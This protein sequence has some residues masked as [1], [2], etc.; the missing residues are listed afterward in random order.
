MSATR[1]LIY[2]PKQSKLTPKPAKKKPGQK[3]SVLTWI[4]N[5]YQFPGKKP[6]PLPSPHLP[7]PKPSPNPITVP[8]SPD[9]PPRKPAEGGAQ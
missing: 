4:R 9:N 3:C 5:G 8:P 2:F 1:I 6:K 7:P